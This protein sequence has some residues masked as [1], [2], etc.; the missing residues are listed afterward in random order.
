[1]YITHCGC[2]HAVVRTYMTPDM[3]VVATYDHTYIRTY[4]PPYSRYRVITEFDAAGGFGVDPVTGEVFIAAKL[5]F[6]TR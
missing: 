1:M 2:I 4:V 3:P 6:D 5:D